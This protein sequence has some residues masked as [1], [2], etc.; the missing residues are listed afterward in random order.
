MK[1]LISAIKIAHKKV[2]IEGDKL[3]TVVVADEMTIDPVTEPL[4]KDL[5][6]FI[7]FAA[8]MLFSRSNTILGK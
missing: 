1:P 2:S 5:R 6:D 3:Q 8:D 7:K 4:I